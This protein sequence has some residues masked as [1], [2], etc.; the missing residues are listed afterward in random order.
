MKK[1]GVLHR[2]LAALIASLGHR[3][4]I[5][6]ADSGLP[7]PPGVNCIDLAVTKGIPPLL[8]VLQVILY[9]MV[10]ERV[11]IADELQ[12]NQS[13]VKSIA[14]EVTPVSLEVVSHEQLKSLSQ[15][16]RAVIRTG[17]WTPYANV[18]L[19]SGVAF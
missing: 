14:D 6:V 15:R 3:D 2:D 8:P 7:V 5:V 12:V 11:V 16:A 10:V 19:Y 1:Q 4:A 9:E 18:I 13:L 17:E